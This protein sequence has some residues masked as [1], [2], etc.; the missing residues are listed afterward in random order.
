M[1]KKKVRVITKV[2]D[3][4]TVIYNSDRIRVNKEL[5]GELFFEIDNELTTDLAEAIAIVLNKGINDSIFW[6]T[7]FNINIQNISPDKTLY[8][9]SGGD[10]E[11]ISKSHYEKSWSDVYLTFQEEYGL[12]IIDTINKAKT[13]GDIRN[14]FL[15][16]LNLP[17]LYEFSLEKGYIK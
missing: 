16:K 4:S 13:F 14:E 1:K 7:T 3:T 12:F 5:N 8:W 2:R 9:M 6:K 10:R 15:K 17:T 11:W